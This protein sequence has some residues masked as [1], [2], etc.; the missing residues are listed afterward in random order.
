M[1]A[2]GC[3]EK[4]RSP[5]IEDR[6]CPECGREIEVFLLGGRSETGI[7]NIFYGGRLLYFLSGFS[8]NP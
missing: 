1:I 8:G 7:C 3:E 5:V 2:F 4:N 6:I